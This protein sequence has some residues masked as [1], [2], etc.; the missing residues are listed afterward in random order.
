MSAQIFQ[1]CPICQDREVQSTFLNVHDFYKIDCRACGRY[2]LESFV[3]EL[4]LFTYEG[5][6]WTPVRR[7]ALAY[8]L[9]TRR[10]VPLWADFKLPFVDRETLSNFEKT[11]IFLPNRLE[12]MDNAVRILATLEISQGLVPN[13]LPYW[14]LW[15]QA[16]TLNSIGLADL[17]EDLAREGM[18]VPDLDV[19][20]DTSRI[21]F[22]IANARLSLNGWRRWDQLTQGAT[23]SAG[24]FI[25]MQ[26]GNA[27]LDSF[28]RD[29]VQVG[30]KERLGV[31]I[32]RI[33]S[34]DKAKAGL[35]DNIMR[36][37]I[38]DAA[39]VLVE[40]SHGNRGAYW[41]AGLA[42]GLRKPV[43]YLCEQAV[44]DDVASRPHFDVNHRTTI[45]WD[46]AKP[47][48]FLDRL[49]ATIKNSIRISDERGKEK[50]G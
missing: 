33:D 10:D 21:P 39:F 25:A 9:R 23:Q 36:E 4:K 42:E 19:Q 50:A 48:E 40:L 49:V 38:E 22:H 1:H 30:V 26:F 2:L 37:A 13:P 12:Q 3:V 31:I 29:I 5:T 6:W 18:I 35:I 28:V 7:A 14:G 20:R 32:H 27:R 45:M 24:G 47:D 46:E 8:K 11:G 17:L 43:I 16:G 44:W 15:A 41:E 34:P